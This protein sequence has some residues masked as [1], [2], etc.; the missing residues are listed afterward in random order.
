MREEMTENVSATKPFSIALEPPGE[1]AAR[2]TAAR[3]AEEVAAQH[4]PRAEKPFALAARD[5]A[6]GWIGGIN[7]V[8][9]WR[10]LYVSQ[11]FVVPGQRGRGLGRA[12]LAAAEIFARENG[13]V[14]VYLDTFSPEAAAF[15]RKCGFAIAGKIENFP[16]GAVR[17]FL[18]K[19]I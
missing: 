15:Y 7:G 12:L 9:H 18:K 11:F 17:T 3:L 5:A 16:P 6:G 2:E 14:G 19:G 8:I 1:E 10:W 13:C 4:G